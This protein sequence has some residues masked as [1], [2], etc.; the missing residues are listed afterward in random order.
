MQ[1]RGP[2]LGNCSLNSARGL[3]IASLMGSLGVHSV[4]ERVCNVVMRVH[5]TGVTRHRKVRNSARK[6][7][8]GPN[9][10]PLSD[11]TEKN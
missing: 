9:L 1:R 5:K 11:P 10:K 6:L 3:V 2:C 7:M 4:V 8:A